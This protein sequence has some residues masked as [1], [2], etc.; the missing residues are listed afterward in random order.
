MRGPA[1]LAVTAPFV[2]YS[3]IGSCVFFLCCVKLICYGSSQIQCSDRYVFQCRFAALVFVP[4]GIDAL[5]TIG[6]MR[7]LYVGVAG[8]LL[9][10]GSSMVMGFFPNLHSVR[11]S[12][13]CG[14]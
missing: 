7:V 6:V 1:W 11:L 12:I 4:L 9:F 10:G 3:N 14:H 8:L 2:L 5:R 13:Y